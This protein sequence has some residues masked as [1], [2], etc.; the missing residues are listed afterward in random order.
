[1][2]NEIMQAKKEESSLTSDSPAIRQK[3]S[4]R[5]GREFRRYFLHRRRKSAADHR[6]VDKRDEFR[7][8]VSRALGGSRAVGLD[9]PRHLERRRT[10]G[11]QEFGVR[12]QVEEDRC[13]EWPYAW[14]PYIAAITGVAA[15][16]GEAAATNLPILGRLPPRTT[17]AGGSAIR[18]L[19]FRRVAARIP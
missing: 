14:D 13:D 2:Y 6:I 10:C 11:T 12:P 3:A 16:A 9:P 18:Y 19:Q 5:R 8:R 15:C 4:R 7:I 17:G 1:M